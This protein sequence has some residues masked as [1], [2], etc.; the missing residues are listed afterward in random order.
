MIYIIKNVVILL[1]CAILFLN[2]W[3]VYV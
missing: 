3:L 2:L 1:K